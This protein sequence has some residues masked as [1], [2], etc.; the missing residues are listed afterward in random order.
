MTTFI[1]LV[2]AGIA[3][4]AVQASFAVTIPAGTTLIVRT[5]N[6]ISSVDTPGKPVS[7]QLDRDV[8]VNGKV[9]LP[10]A[11][12]I[13]GRVESLWVY[14]AAPILGALLAVVACR[15]V[16]EKGCCCV[17]QESSC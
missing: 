9:A 7:M 17:T 16:Q 2:A 11:T 12:K 4:L 1:R 10:A 15:C 3:C 5:L 8:S 13:S 6:G 14:L